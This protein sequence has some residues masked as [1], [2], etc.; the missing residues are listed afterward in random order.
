MAP[1][2]RNV[3]GK[4]KAVKRHTSRRGGVVGKKVHRKTPAQ[5]RAAIL[6]KIKHTIHKTKLLIAKSRRRRAAMGLGGGGL[7]LEHNNVLGDRNG[8]YHCSD[9]NR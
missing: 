4:K 3:H 5:A 8:G 9:F 7:G 6:R 2:R 1:S